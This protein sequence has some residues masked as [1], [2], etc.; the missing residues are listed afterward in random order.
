MYNKN[1]QIP[2]LTKKLTS[3]WLKNESHLMSCLHE[4]VMKFQA[5]AIHILRKIMT[6][7]CTGQTDRQG[8]NSLPPSSE[9]RYRSKLIYST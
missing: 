7:I 6:K 1:K 9:R 5:S 3:D 4:V 2:N 8:E